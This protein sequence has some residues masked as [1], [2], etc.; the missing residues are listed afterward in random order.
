MGNSTQ[1]R[2]VPKNVQFEDVWAMFQETDQMMKDTARLQ[3]ETDQMI[4]DTDRQM[5]ETD[6]RLDKMM[7]E[8]DKKIGKLGNRFGELV[9]HLVMPNMVEKFRAL[10]YAFT[11][12]GPGIE[13]YDSKGKPLAEVDLWLENGEFALAVEVKSCLH[14]QDIKDHVRRMET[15]CRY[16]E[17]RNDKRKFLAAAA[18]AIVRQNVR[19]YAVKNGFYVIEQSGDTVKIEVPEGFRPRIWQVSS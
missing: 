16:A 11:K 15:L 10:G 6:R 3:K 14:I 19:E 8:T 18:G 12:A 9:E 2:K 7:A 5:K 4:K 17:E 13:F 1:K